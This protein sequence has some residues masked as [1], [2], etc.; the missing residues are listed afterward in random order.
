MNTDTNRPPRLAIFASGSGSN[1]QKIVEYFQQKPQKAEI[2]LILSNKA[3]AGVLDRA[4]ALGVPSKVFD[5]EDFYTNGSVL[6]LLK[7]EQIDWVILAG[8]LWLVPTELLEAYPNRVVNLHPALLP[9]FGGKGMYGMN[10]HQAVINAKE[11][12]TGITI[13]YANAAFDEGKV[14][15]QAKCKVEV[16]DTPEIVAEK[17]HQLEHQH[18]PKVIAELLETQ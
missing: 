14:I 13:H 2:R 12:E 1:A 18:F 10:V 11:T 16:Q 17:I 15:F 7:S 5:R 6:A 3:K 8:F 9:K 4:A